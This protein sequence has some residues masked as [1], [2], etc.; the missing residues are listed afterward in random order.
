MAASGNTNRAPSSA[1]FRMGRKEEL[2]RSLVG[3]IFLN[4]FKTV[5]FLGEGS[6]ALV[7]LAHPLDQ[8]DKFVVVKSI[9][10][11]VLNGPRFKQFF[12]AEVSS[13]SR[14]RHAYAVGFYGA[15]LDDPNGPCL[16]LEYI[17]GHT[18]E[19]VLSRHVRLPY[20]RVARLL[21]PLCHVLQAAHDAGIVHR[22]LKPANL[23]VLN[24]NTPH[25]TVRV[26][27]FGF[28]GFTAKPHIQL[29]ELTGH[30]PVFACGTPA[31]V[32]P[33][34]IRSDTVDHRADLYSLGVM[35]FEM[36]TGRLPFEA[37]TTE[38]M[39]RSHLQDSPPKFSQVGLTDCPA[40][41]EAA[42]QL[43]LCK[44]PNERHQS[45]KEL[46]AMFSKALNVDLWEEYQP[47][48]P[49]EPSA[50]E[51]IILCTPA[52]PVP[53]PPPAEDKFLLSDRFEALMPERLAA[54][55]L[56]GFIEDVAGVAI[57]SEPGLIRV[58]L[59]VP[60][61]WQDPSTQR[62]GSKFLSWMSAFRK[63][64]FS[65]DKEP[66]E[67]DLQMSKLDAN[68]VSVLVTFRPIKPYIPRKVPIWQSRCEAY[69]SILR[70]YLMAGT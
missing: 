35:I 32:S 2:Q 37:Q 34:M 15:S 26:M 46:L 9:K 54:A 1:F 33:E 47:E 29:A 27:D 4:N 28:A 31:Y 8:P 70:K 22:D 39:L 13:M 49:E 3:K 12:E 14:F 10:P 20:E 65:V 53:T 63:P 67:L 50:D 6:N 41:I 18:L 60:Q 61:G 30:G 69:Y 25:E 19:H 57:A 59:E 21:A 17:P 38:E 64:T 16:V 66:I 7:F 56:R 43:A 45:A 52:P 48:L 40:I 36:L 11:H 51:E 5:S 55:K 68:R 58:H 62:E 42:V 44:Y 23:M 24:A